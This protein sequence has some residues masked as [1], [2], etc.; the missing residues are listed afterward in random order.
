MKEG[1]IFS[2]EI[3]RDTGIIGVVSKMNIRV[4]DEKVAEIRNEEVKDITIPMDKARVQI[5]QMGAKS[6]EVRVGDGDRFVLNTTFWGKYGLF[7][8]IIIATVA[9]ILI[10][11]YARYGVFIVYFIA[12]LTVDGLNIKLSKIPSDTQ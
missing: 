6:N 8:L 5:T 1:D 10:N 4:N 2:V 9:G 11:N 12:L 7:L 3:K